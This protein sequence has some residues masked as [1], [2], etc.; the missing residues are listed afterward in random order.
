VK[1]FILDMIVTSHAT[2]RMQTTLDG[3]TV[4][5]E[6]VLPVTKASLREFCLEL[7]VDTDLISLSPYF[8]D[9]I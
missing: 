3:L 5:V 6:K 8:E 2:S 9:S 7:I 1:L 4:T